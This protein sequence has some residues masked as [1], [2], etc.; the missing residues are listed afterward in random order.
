MKIWIDADATPRDAKE[1]VFRASLRLQVETVLVANQPLRPPPGQ[2][3]I[4]AVLVPGHPDA[5]DRH[6][7]EQAAAGDLAVTADLPL[8]A[9][10]VARQVTVVDPRGVEYRPDNIGERLATRNLLDVLRGAGEVTGG[11]APYG[12][13]ERQA[14]AATF[15]RV[16]VKRLKS[17]AARS[18]PMLKLDNPA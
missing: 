1:I 6:I 10:L 15:D 17:Q 8:A 9:A 7:I 11:P 18:V 2:S 4:T 12:L 14:F 3:L 13:K 5:A 16:L